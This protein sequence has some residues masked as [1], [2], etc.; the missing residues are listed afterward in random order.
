MGFLS[1]FIIIFFFLKRTE[2]HW[3]G[4]FLTFCLHFLLFALTFTHYFSILLIKQEKGPP[5]V[6]KLKKTGET[7]GFPKARKGQR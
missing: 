2:I 1:A 6:K 5:E 7:T 3:W 4:F